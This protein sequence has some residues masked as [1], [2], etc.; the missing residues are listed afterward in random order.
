MGTMRADGNRRPRMSAIRQ[1]VAPLV[2]SQLGRLA[3]EG[4][5]VI[6]DALDHFAYFIR[7]HPMTP[8]ESTDFII[9][10]PGD[11][12]AVGSADQ[13]FVVGHDCLLV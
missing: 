2:A 10:V 7:S 12:V 11:A 5:A 8:G 13:I 3:F 1:G 9:L 6:A 4:V